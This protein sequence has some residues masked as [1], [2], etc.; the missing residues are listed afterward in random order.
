MRGETFLRFMLTV[1]A[2]GHEVMQHF[3]K[4]KDEKRSIVVLE[5]DQYIN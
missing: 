5:N 3:H 1:I 4:P 2:D